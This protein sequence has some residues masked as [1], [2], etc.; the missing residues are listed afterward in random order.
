MATY[1][2]SCQCGKIVY[3]FESGPITEG[4]ECNC[5]MC[6][7][8]G[9]ILHFIPAAS[10]TL[11]TAREN[12]ST[13][14]FNKH[15]IAHHFCDVCGVAPFSEGADPKGNKMV[16][17]NLRCVEGVDPRALKLNFHNGAVD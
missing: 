10:F 4:L 5:S 1:S 11:K 9:V 8:K 2:G 13:Y 14:K 16:A 12:V 15:V 6:G 17:I 3:D 7:R